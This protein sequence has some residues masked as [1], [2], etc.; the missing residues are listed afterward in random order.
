MFSILC[1]FNEGRIV[2]SQLMILFTFSIFT[3]CSYD[4]VSTWLFRNVSFGRLMFSR[5]AVLFRCIVFVWHHLMHQVLCYSFVSVFFYGFLVIQG[6][7]T[8]HS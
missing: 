1:F 3:F 5:F 6:Q 7:K 8:N 2:F 4:S